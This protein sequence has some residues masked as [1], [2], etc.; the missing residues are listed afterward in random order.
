VLEQSWADGLQPLME[1]RIGELQG[2]AATA[3]PFRRFMASQ[4]AE[5]DLALFLD[6]AR[7]P[8]VPEGAAP[9]SSPGAPC[10]PPSS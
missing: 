7:L 6:L 8:P 10:C 5:A 3:E 1:G 2:L 9:I 4:V